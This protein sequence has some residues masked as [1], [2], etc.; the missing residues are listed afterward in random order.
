MDKTDRLLR[1]GII[2]F[3]VQIKFEREVKLKESIW[4]R[5]LKR[6]QKDV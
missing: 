2:K 1:F 6:S 3:K 4:I 5:V